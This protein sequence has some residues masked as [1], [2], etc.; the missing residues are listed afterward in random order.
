M[1]KRKCTY[2]NSK[3]TERARRSLLGMILGTV[4]NIAYV[5]GGIDVYWIFCDHLPYCCAV[6]GYAFYEQ[7]GRVLYLLIGCAVGML[8]LFPLL[9]CWKFSKKH[10]GWMIAALVLFSLDTLLIVVDVIRDQNISYLLGIVI[11]LWV[12]T[13]MV[14]AICAGEEA[15][16]EMETTSK[17]QKKSFRDNSVIGL[18]DTSALGMPQEERKYRVIV[19]TMYG[20]RTVQVR[21]SYGLTELVIDGRLYGKREGVAEMPYRLTARVDGHEIATALQPN[22]VQTI[23]VDGRI[24]AKKF[25]L[26]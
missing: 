6:S 10:R 26:R 19:E 5:A 13:A 9:L 11:H 3:L 18:S 20:S 16:A 17:A 8:I 4:F 23:E 1:E 7:S 2:E 25:R 12:I 24:V 22:N 21:R 15:V 14:R